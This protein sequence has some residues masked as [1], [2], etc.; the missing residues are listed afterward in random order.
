MSDQAPD[1]SRIHFASVVRVF[2]KYVL[3]MIGYDMEAEPRD[4]ANGCPLE[5]CR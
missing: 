1:T 4:E 5:D 2:P 3:A